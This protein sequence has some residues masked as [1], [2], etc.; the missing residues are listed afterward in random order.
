[1]D[2]YWAALPL[3]GRRVLVVGG[4]PA[5][6]PR[7]AA[8]RAARAVV[9]VIAPQALA[10]ITD[11]AD[12][13]LI[14]WI[15]R[16]LGPADIGENW[17]V[18]AAAGDPDVDARTIELADQAAVFCLPGSELRDPTTVGERRSGGRVILV[19]GGPGDPGLVTLSGLAAIRQ[20]D[21]IVTDRLAPLATLDEAPKGAEVIDVSKIPKGTTTQQEVINQLLVE[22]ARAG[23]TVVRFKGGDSF[24]FG[25]GGEELEA[26]L[27]AGVEVQVIPGVTSAIAGPELAG[28][29]VTHRGLNQGFTVISGHVPPGDPRSTLDF[30]ALARTGTDLV[31]MM[32]VATLPAITQALLDAGMPP[33]TPAATVADAGLASQ[34]DLRGTLATIA[35]MNAAARIRSPAVTVIGA[36]AGFDPGR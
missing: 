33:E 34:R 17:L 16:E 4:G 5:A 30:A 1:M 13:K 35:G 12:R 26:C 23:Q 10:A 19:G 2:D 15:P 25:R 31:L 20:A 22:H 3:A 9:T 14:R 7:I 32:A 24:V 36:V 27:A 8:V 18:F 29:P 6:L 21:V 11:M 28:I